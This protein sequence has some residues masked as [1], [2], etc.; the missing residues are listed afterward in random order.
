MSATTEKPIDMEAQLRSLWGATAWPF[1]AAVKDAMETEAYTRTLRRLEQCM[2]VRTCGILWG[3]NGVG[4]SRLVKTLVDRLPQKAYH[5][6]ILT[7]SSLTGTDITRYLCHA[8]GIGVAQRR[9]DNIM[10]LRKLWADQGGIWPVLIFEEAQNLSTSALE[11]LRLLSCDRLDTQPP[12]SLLMV[13]DG[14][15]LPRLN[16]G[17]NRPLLSRMGFCLELS[18]WTPEQCSEYL[19]K[20]LA[21]VGIRENVFDPDAELLLLRIAGGIP[22]AINHLGQRAFEEAARDRSRQIQAIHVQH[23]LEQLPWLGT[24]RND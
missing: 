8:Q 15:L 1:G 13:G 2:A 5:T 3:P 7:H 11:E 24:I 6:M 22:R 18:T 17:I 10:S 21:D 12:F 9:S 23:A 14:A 16:M 4:K 20:R 19:G